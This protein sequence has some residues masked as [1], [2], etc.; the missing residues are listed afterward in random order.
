[1]TKENA[2]DLLKAVVDVK[3]LGSGSIQDETEKKNE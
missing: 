3:K 1:M 2:G